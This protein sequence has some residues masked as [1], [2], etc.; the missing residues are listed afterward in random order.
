MAMTT[1]PRP[2]LFSR[3]AFT[4]RGLTWRAMPRGRVEGD[5]LLF[6]VLH[7]LI[8]NSPSPKC[9]FSPLPLSR[10]VHMGKGDSCVDVEHK[11]R[12]RP[13]LPRTGLPPVIFS[14]LP[15]SANFFVFVFVFPAKT[16]DE[17]AI[18]R[19]PK[20]EESDEDRKDDDDDAEKPK[21]KSKSKKK[22]L[23]QQLLLLQQQQSKTSK[24]APT[25]RDQ[26]MLEPYGNS[27]RSSSDEGE[28][29]SPP[30]MGSYST[31]LPLHPQLHR[32][33]IPTH[34]QQ[35]LMGQP[36]GGLQPGLLVPYDY[37]VLSVQSLE[38]QIAN[39]SPECELLLG[40]IPEELVGRTLYDLISPEDAEPL[41]H[42][43]RS[44]F[45]SRLSLQGS[46]FVHLKT[47]AGMYVPCD[48][49]MQVFKHK[50]TGAA[51]SLLCSLRPAPPKT[52][53]FQ[54]DPPATLQHLQQQQQQQ[55][56]Q[57]AIFN[58]MHMGLPRSD[59]SDEPRN[60]ILHSQSFDRLSSSLHGVKFNSQVQ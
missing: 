33:E 42:L 31:S 56:Q 16:L 46:L 5:L 36:Q 41:A 51:L 10:C 27:G 59:Y 28:S 13:K 60:P 17:G 55:Q 19:P 8:P 23:L 48:V 43:H 14:S 34:F 39:I 50:D 21:R 40:F 11:K 35:P 7:S 6:L 12:G 3:P 44:L 54:D 26:G 2:N 30:S 49:V 37:E 1:S 29:S 38:G 4:A 47:K 45:D 58:P 18:I 57:Q 32:T 15:L 22:K 20:S 24:E 25:Q 52:P 9:T 53:Q